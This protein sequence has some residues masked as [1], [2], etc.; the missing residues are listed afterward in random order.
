MGNL[1]IS[2]KLS[3]GARP[4]QFLIRPA[5]CVANRARR[6]RRVYR[7]VIAERSRP[8]GAEERRE[9]VREA[10]LRASLAQGV[11][12]VAGWAFRADAPVHVVVPA[13]GRAVGVGLSP[14]AAK[15]AHAEPGVAQGGGPLRVVSGAL[16]VYGLAE[17]GGGPV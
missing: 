8:H 5:V 12:A 14:L 17:Q 7:R 10:A 9:L 13:A 15:I 16:A 3:L 6:L 2:R 1:G 4:A 11:R